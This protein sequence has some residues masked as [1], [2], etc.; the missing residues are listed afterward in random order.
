[1]TKNSLQRLQQRFPLGRLSSFPILWEDLEDELSN[2]GAESTDLSVSEDSN[3]VYVEAALPGLKP[4]EIE[5]TLD[6]GILWIRGEK[7]EEEKNSERKYYRKSSSQ[8]SYRLSLPG[9]IDEHKEPTASYKD[10]IITLTFQKA[11][12]NQSKKISVKRA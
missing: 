11:Q 3:N 6:K 8:F 4:E 12:K 2:L 7:K 10:G 5:I 9:Q 1:M